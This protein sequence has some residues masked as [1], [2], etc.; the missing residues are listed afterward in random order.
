MNTPRTVDIGSLRH[1]IRFVVP[2]Q[3][4]LSYSVNDRN[5]RCDWYPDISSSSREDD[6]HTLRTKSFFSLVHSLI[7]PSKEEKLKKVVCT[8][9]CDG[10]LKK[11]LEPNQISRCQIR[12][13]E[14]RPTVSIVLKLHP[15]RM[16]MTEHIER[17]VLVQIRM[18]CRTEHRPVTIFC[19]QMDRS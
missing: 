10:Q 3:L 17:S 5:N 13:K 8:M 16:I 19:Y 18:C 14:M 7:T 12:I 2:L 11:K 6:S 9:K 1:Q 15:T 4:L